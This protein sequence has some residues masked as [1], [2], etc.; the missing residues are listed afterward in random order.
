MFHR[1]I[2]F[3][4]RIFLAFQHVRTGGKS[5]RRRARRIASQPPRR[6]PTCRQVVGHQQDPDAYT[7]E[8]ACGHEQ[9]PP[10]GDH[11]DVRAS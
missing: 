3:L 10:V 6:C 2:E 5:T 11:R 9:L 4:R 8:A 1:F 7:D